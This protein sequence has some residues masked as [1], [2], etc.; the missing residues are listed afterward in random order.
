MF[1]HVSGVGSER[2]S[3][4]LSLSRIHLKS[5]LFKS[6]KEGPKASTGVTAE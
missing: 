3:S 4:Q 2:Y 5:K 6:Y 1:I